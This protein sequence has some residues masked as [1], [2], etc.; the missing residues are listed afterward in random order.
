MAFSPPFLALLVVIVVLLRRVSH[1]LVL[2]NRILD[3]ASRRIPNTVNRIPIVVLEVH[4][5]YCALD[6]EH[7]TDVLVTVSGPFLLA[8]THEQLLTT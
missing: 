3:E 4:F 6:R 1:S 2:I 7:L 5:A 8:F